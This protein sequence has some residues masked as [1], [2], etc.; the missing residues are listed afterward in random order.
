MRAGVQRAATIVIAL[1][2]AACASDDWEP[3]PHA[4]MPTIPRVGDGL[5]SP[6]RIV[7]IT[8]PGETLAENLARFGDHLARGAWWSS[9]AA[10]YALAPPAGHV[11]VTG[12]A[13]WSFPE[14]MHRDEVQAYI[15]MVID[16]HPELAPDGRTVY[17]LYLPDS[18]I[19]APTQSIAH[20]HHFPLAG[21]HGAL[22]DAGA[23]I[24]RNPAAVSEL[25]AL[26]AI[27]SHEIAEAA[28]DR[29]GGWGLDT[30]DGW[31]LAL[32]GRRPWDASVWVENEV[33]DKAES[34]DL[35]G[36]TRVRIDGFAYQRIFS[37]R[38]ALDAGDPCVPALD[39]PYFNATTPA[40]WYAAAAGSTI[41]IPLIG[42]STEATS[43]WEVTVLPRAQRPVPAD[44]AAQVIG[45]R[46]TAIGDQTYPLLQ[47]GES[48]EIEVHLPA[49]VASGWWG[50]VDIHSRH[51][52]PATG[53]SV[54]G[55]DVLHQ[56]VVGVYLQ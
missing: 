29:G 51:L 17:L 14:G 3:A 37:N 34:A 31:I 55:E 22:G 21:S 41:T 39:L 30:G 45:A 35:C 13:P 46:T 32:D 36:G 12:P 25:D 56:Y 50:I 53:R 9:F 28:T 18:V 26:T 10:E 5:L 24:E 11:A 15:A 38:A 42:W 6:V 40:S 23:V 44:F 48:V 4:P 19:L 2:V 43:D 52:D 47:N 49:G 33:S 8:M 1:G 16:A 54:P 7:T 27:A 20:G